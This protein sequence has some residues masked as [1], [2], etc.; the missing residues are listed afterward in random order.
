MNV[1]KRNNFGYSLIETMTVIAVIAIVLGL[2][3]AYQ[4]RGWKLFYQSYSRGLSQIK[5]KTA[6]RVLSDDLR[7]ANRNRIIIS[8]G[9]SFGVP[10]PDDIQSS[11]PYIYFTKPK[12]HEQTSEII[13]YD[14][15]LY[16]FSRPKEKYEQFQ[17][18]K[19]TKEP[20]LVLKSI[21]FI[22]Q[23]RY[24]TEDQ[25]K[26]W[27]FLPPILELQKST[28][29]EDEVFIESLK[30][31]NPQTITEKSKIEDNLFLDH[32][33]RIKKESRNIPLSGNFSATALTDP[34][35]KEEINIFFGLDYK[36]DKPIKIKVAIEEAPFLFG[37]M[38]ANTEFE[39]KVTPRN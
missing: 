7:E 33:S 11:S 17:M 10:L 14:Y 15:I 24:Y 37:L 35:S 16:Y 12:T 23:S 6:I 13:A 19:K 36:N 28:L 29:P 8:R 20:Y 3:F 2:L 18:K 22:N 34:F 30:S 5:A 38:S 9:T 27:P 39:V 25:D 31:S 32:F 1:F 4:E 21:K 26:T